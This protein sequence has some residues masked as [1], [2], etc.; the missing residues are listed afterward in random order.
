M[1]RVLAFFLIVLAAGLGFAWL[2]DNPGMVSLTWQGQHVETSFLVFVIA[3]ALLIFAALILAWLIVAF[4]RTPGALG[5]YFRRRKRDRG[6]D[7]LSRGILA[8]G[9]GD[10]VAA[11]RLAKRSEKLLG[12]RREPLVRF[13]D[14]QTAM[15]EGDHQRAHAAFESMERDPQTRL[16]ALRGLYL[17]AERAGNETAARH[18]AEEAARIAPQ[19]P[20]AGGAVLEAK[21]LEKDWDGALQILEA[22]RESRLVGRDD[23]KRLRAVLLTAKAKAVAD[24]DPTTA[25][26]AAIEAHKLAP[27]L[28]PAA[29]TAARALFRLGDIR[30][31]AKILESA[32]TTEPHPEIAEAYV[33]AR[34]GDSTSE[35]LKRAKTLQSLRPNH[36]E[37]S[38]CVAHAALDAHDFALAREEALA[39]SRMGPRESVFLLLADIEEAEGGNEGK[40]RE[41]LSRALRAP[42][43]PAWTA[44]GMVSEE[45]QPISPVTGRLDAFRWK[46]PVQRLGAAEPLN[47]SHEEEAARP[48]VEHAPVTSASTQPSAE[49][50]PT[51][52]AASPS[53]VDADD[54]TPPSTGT[55][56]PPGGQEHGEG[57]RMRLF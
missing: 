23:S 29:V 6:Y 28:A 12:N 48:L 16:L 25:K 5:G 45:W 50:H 32:W 49:N 40:M 47:I 37:S 24:A 42:R 52:G 7:A 43:D 56:P 1:L 8:A 41:W 51:S 2:A 53:P 18:Y 13:L 36:V 34:L 30:R 22:Q 54:E 21:S 3:E 27:D 14:A 10:A 55:T 17:E 19:L 38:I 33:N 44:D 15:I 46:V 9:A 35:R 57:G 26:N 11:R 39:A 4:F 20:W 31:G